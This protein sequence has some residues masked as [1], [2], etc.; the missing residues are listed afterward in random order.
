MHE[1]R[2]YE[3]WVLSMKTTLT[4]LT[5]V[6]TMFASSASAFD[7]DD[8]QKLKDTGNCEECALSGANL[9]MDADLE[10]ANLFKA[11]LVDAYLTDARLLSANLESANL[12]GAAMRGVILCNTTMPDGSVIYSGC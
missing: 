2:L 12:R 10:G 11:F 7:P 8:L 5:I 1:Q 6:A 4:A 9:G 3:V